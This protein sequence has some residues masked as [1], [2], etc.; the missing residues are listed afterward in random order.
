[1]IDQGTLISAAAFEKELALSEESKKYLFKNK[2]IREIEA[3]IDKLQETINKRSEDIKTSINEKQKIR[4]NLERCEYEQKTA[5]DYSAY[6][7][8]R[9]RI[10]EVSEDIEVLEFSLKNIIETV[11]PA[12][13]YKE[14]IDTLRSEY[15][16]D[17]EKRSAEAR[18]HLKA[19]RELARLSALDRV[20]LNS[21]LNHLTN[22]LTR[23][24]HE[25]IDNSYDNPLA[26]LA[27][28]PAS[29]EKS[30]IEI[31][32]RTL[33]SNGYALKIENKKPY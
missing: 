3:E 8:S 17:I 7:R 2:K 16:K 25:E 22:T 27:G 19:L 20:K 12:D 31:L 6:K 26:R 5:G 15:N 30:N 21:L 14:L 4:A 24:V 23:G 11:L 32:G 33:D 29:V 28:A 9:Q 10:N 1:M 18:E 13:H